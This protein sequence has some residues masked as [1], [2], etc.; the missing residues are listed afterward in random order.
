MKK[1]K[2]LVSELSDS[3]RLGGYERGIIQAINKEIQEIEKE[4]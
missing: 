2:E 1:L 4:M 3:Q